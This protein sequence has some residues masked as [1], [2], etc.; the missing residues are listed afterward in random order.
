MTHRYHLDCGSC[1]IIFGPMFSR[2]STT[3]R[4]EIT[5]LADIGLKVLYV[6]SAKDVRNSQVQDSDTSTHHS[7]FKGFSDKVTR[8]KTSRLGDLNINKYD[9]IGIDEG[10]F[11]EDLEVTVRNWVLKKTK[12]VII[13]SLDG[14][15]MMRPFGQA[16]TLICLCE[17]GDIVKLHAFCVRCTQDSLQH[18]KMVRIPAGFTAKFQIDPKVIEGESYSQE[19]PGSEDKYLP[20]CMK[21]YQEHMASFREEPIISVDLD[22]LD[23]LDALELTRSVQ[24]NQMPMVH[25]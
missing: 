1:R 8:V 20:V 21:C 16:H 24:T 12:I 23:A 14:D 11:F 2:K 6:N 3:L 13:A 25:Y 5:T 15:F 4:D 19:D 10:Q 22:A 9:A 18:G 7:G 17:P